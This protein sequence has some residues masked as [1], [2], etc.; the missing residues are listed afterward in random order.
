MVDLNRCLGTTIMK[1]RKRG[2]LTDREE[3]FCAEYVVDFNVA[4]AAIRAGYD[5]ESAWRIGFR[6][7]D[8]PRILEKTRPWLIESSPYLVNGRPATNG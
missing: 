8:D 2:A 6:L 7:L 4:Q 3:K 5:P 1:C